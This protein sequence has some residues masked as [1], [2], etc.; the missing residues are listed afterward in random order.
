MPADFHKVIP[1]IVK[2]R[3]YSLEPAGQNN[4][5]QEEATDYPNWTAQD[6]H[7][8]MVK[9]GNVALHLRVEFLASDSF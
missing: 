5:H 6:E 2:I 7:V 1:T 3:E 8:S 9:Q 4:Y